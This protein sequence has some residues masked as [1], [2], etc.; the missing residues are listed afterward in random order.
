MKRFLVGLM[1]AAMATIG[2]GS[3][4][5][6][7]T[8]AWTEFVYNS[9]GNALKGVALPTSSDGTAS[10]NFASGVYTATLTTS[11]KSLTGD[12]TGKTLSDAI[13]V[14]GVNG[15]FVDQN[16][17]GTG[18]T[19]PPSVRLFFNSG[20][21]GAGGQRGF[22]TTFWWSNPVSLPLANG[23]PTTISESLANT[24]GWSDWNGQ[25]ANSSSVVTAAFNT[26]ATKV[27]SVGLSF[28]GG[29]FFENGVTTG[30][31]SGTFNSSFSET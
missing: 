20:G 13:T 15:T 23:G 29:C 18:C 7:T 27:L 2:F 6:A 31:G 25:E 5:S 19:T 22:F 3:V 26:A 9:S 4:A 24:A 1:V 14:S 11:D 8:S 17:G 21:T 28:G 12:L 16:G 10:F 30:D